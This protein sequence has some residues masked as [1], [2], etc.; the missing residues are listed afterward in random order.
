MLAFFSG[1]LGKVV[2]WVAGIVAIAGV[3]FGAKYLYDSALEAR[4]LLEYNKKQ[5]EEV[6]RAQEQYIRKLEELHEL[7]KQVS[8]E[9]NKRIEEMDEKFDGINEFI[10][11]TDVDGKDKP[12]SEIL[13]ETVRRLRTQK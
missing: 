3:I 12:S 11:S 5:L 10:D 9:L 1:T 13:K 2:L 4:V 7:Q 6:V 8:E